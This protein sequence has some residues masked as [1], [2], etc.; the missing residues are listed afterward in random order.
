MQSQLIKLF[1]TK[2]TEVMFTA[3]RKKTGIILTLAALVISGVAAYD[4]PNKKYGEHQNLKVL[5]KDI[6]DDS[7]DAIMD[8]FKAALG[9]RCNYCHAP[10]KDPNQKWPDF[11]SDD[12]PEKEIA[13]HMMRMTMNINANFFN[14]DNSTKPDTIQVVRCYTCHRGIQH[15]DPET[16]GVP[17]GK[18][19]GGPPPAGGGQGVPPPPPPPQGKP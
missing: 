12:K 14:F 2:T 19:P 8:G 7:L 15:P 5:P 11:A 4:P 1:T 9:V 16:I 18:G 10:S 17:S 6:S 13:R 3:N